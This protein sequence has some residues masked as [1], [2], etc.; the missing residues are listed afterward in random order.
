MAA[1]TLLPTVTFTD[2]THVP[3]LGQGT[4]RM[5]DDPARAPAEAQAL[6]L[7]LDLGMTVVDTAEMYGDGGAE[8]VVAR[9]LAG[10]RDEAF[11][12]SK[13]YPHNAGRK[14]LVAA[15]ERS[16]ARLRTDRIDLYLLHWRGPTPL[17]ETV[18]GFEALRA[19]GKI[20]RWGVSNFARAD[21]EELAAVPGGA[22]C[23]ANQ[24]LWHLCERGIEWDLVPWMR[25]R[26]MPVI[27]YSP[28]AEGALARDRRLKAIAASTDLTAAQLALAWLLAQPQTLVIPQSSQPAH[29]RANRAA[30]ATAL[31][32]ATRAQLDAAFPPPSGPS[33]LAVI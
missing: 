7:G 14:A 10:R 21:L 25:A 27:A 16:L 2:G 13:V 19:A 23:A 12:I 8:R 9:A 24:V 33:P 31:P 30:A 20:V 15:C 29:V 6:A 22:H 11:V 18:A 1:A 3:A 5:G 26:R 28:L 32:A 17:A 4:W